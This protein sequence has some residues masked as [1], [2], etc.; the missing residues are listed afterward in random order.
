[1][2]EFDL[3]KEDYLDDVLNIYNYYILHT[4]ATFS[5]RPIT[6]E[7]MHKIM[8][9][10]LKRFPSFVIKEGKEIIG[11]VLLARY[12]AREAYDRT[13]EVTIYL[14]EGYEGKGIGSLALKHIE[15]F[16]VKHEFRALLAVI[17]AENEESIALFN[18][19]EYFRCA[20]FKQVGEKFG[21]VLD[22]VIYEKLL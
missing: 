5:I 8:F 16:A 12:K 19:F 4:T 14:K 13:A 6:K 9:S 11:Y 22:V 7:E 15:E 21:R 17:C 18:K 2:I 1:M 3:A 20:D 10:G